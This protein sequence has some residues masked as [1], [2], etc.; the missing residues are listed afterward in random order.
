[1]L[2]S[3][4]I[5]PQL[6]IARLDRAAGARVAFALKSTSISVAKEALAG[7]TYKVL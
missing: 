5:P 2:L 7:A 6:R 1:M 4:A 3:G